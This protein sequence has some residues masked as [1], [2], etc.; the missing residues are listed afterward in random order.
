MTMILD[1]LLCD[2]DT[3]CVL[4]CDDDTGCVVV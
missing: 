3:G 4:L 1:V 2:D